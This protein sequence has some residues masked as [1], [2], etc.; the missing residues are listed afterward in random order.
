M[1]P[2]TKKQV[3]NATRDT[4]KKEKMDALRWAAVRYVVADKKLE[5][6]CG[7]KYD[8]IACTVFA[9][10]GETKYTIPDE[11]TSAAQCLGNIIGLHEELMSSLGMESDDVRAIWFPILNYGVTKAV[12][13]HHPPEHGPLTGRVG[14]LP[15]GSGFGHTKFV[16]VLDNVHSSFVEICTM[17]RGE[18]NSDH[19][20]AVPREMIV[21]LFEN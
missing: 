7:G 6:A 14:M 13:I 5:H 9:W 20:F 15:T 8:P 19:A 21:G 17:E 3:T 1:K 11:S 18:T 2:S 16:V 12:S 4:L 10:K